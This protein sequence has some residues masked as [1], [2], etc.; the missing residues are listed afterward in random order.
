[1]LNKQGDGS[2]TD[3]LRPVCACLLGI[4]LF[5]FPP[6]TADA[7]VASDGADIAGVEI[8]IVPLHLGSDAA[9][10]RVRQD[11]YFKLKEKWPVDLSE[12]RYDIP[13]I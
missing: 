11:L 5:A 12:R 6:F 13:P 9:S 7:T 2:R 10:F 1:M 3:R 8:R 4:M